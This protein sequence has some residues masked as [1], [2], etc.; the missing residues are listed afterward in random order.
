MTNPALLQ[1]SI[2]LVET[3]HPGNIG[4]CAR[5]MKTMGLTDLRLVR[6]KI[7]PSAEATAR[8]AGADNLLASA[9]I[10]DSLGEAIA[11]CALVVGTTARARSIPWPLLEPRECAA[12]LVPLTQTQRIALVFGREHSGLNNDEVELCNLL[13]QIPTNTQF[14]SLNIAAAVQ[15]LG[16]EFL[17][18]SKQ[19]DGTSRPKASMHTPVSAAEMQQFF[20]HLEQALIAIEFLDPEKPRRL[21]RR[22]HRLFNRALP[23]R[24]E[25]NILRGILAAVEK[26]AAK[27]QREQS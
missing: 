16:Y 9:R 25:V 1:I 4:A 19:F 10:Y 23:D 7:F 22:L 12:Q 18:A 20:D 14:S 6:P 13:V 5:A 21:M 24:M 8:A 2:V 27:Q 26:A 17:L 15:L 3:T 11:D